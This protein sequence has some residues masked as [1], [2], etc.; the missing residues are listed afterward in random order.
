M[1]D[2]NKFLRERLR[3]DDA[4]QF[5]SEDA[6]PWWEDGKTVE[7]EKATYYRYLE[8]LPP[9]FMR[10]DLFA[11]GE[12]AGNFVLFW[13]EGSAYFAHSLSVDDT[14]TFCSLARVRL[15]A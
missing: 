8:M 1:S 11:F 10:G 2:L 12:G 13:N 5:A 6:A 9:R 7:V 14:K 15:H 3:S 4:E